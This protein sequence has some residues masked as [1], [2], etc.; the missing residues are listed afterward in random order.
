MFIALESINQF[1]LRRS[2]TEK[3]RRFMP[4]LRSW[5]KVWM[6]FARDMPRLAALSL[7]PIPGVIFLV[8]R[9]RVGEIEILWQYGS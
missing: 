6:D 2:D 9:A 7:T 4:L 3:S 8:P 1:K 5:G